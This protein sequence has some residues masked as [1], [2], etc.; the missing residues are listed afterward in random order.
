VEETKTKPKIKPTTILIA[1]ASLIVIILLVN[2]CTSEPIKPHMEP[3]PPELIKFTQWSQEPPYDEGRPTAAVILEVDESARPNEIY[4]LG[5]WLVRY[6][7]L[8]VGYFIDQGGNH[9][10]YAT[11]GM[12]PKTRQLYGWVRCKKDE[13]GYVAWYPD[14]SSQYGVSQSINTDGEIE[15]YDSD[16][17]E[18]YTEDGITYIPISPIEKRCDYRELEIVEFN[19]LDD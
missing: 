14:I 13:R 10:A 7:D 1:I 2:R 8:P 15:L 5:L 6:P 19:W 16:L 17:T 9:Q 11:R 4:E 12:G 18:P 3:P